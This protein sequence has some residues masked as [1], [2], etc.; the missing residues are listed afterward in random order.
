[1]YTGLLFGP[2][3]LLGLV[4]L[5]PRT[6]LR[7]AQILFWCAV[8]TYILWPNTSAIAASVA[9]IMIGTLG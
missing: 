8:L 6:A 9:N 2:S 1:M 3:F 7:I 5:W 4:M